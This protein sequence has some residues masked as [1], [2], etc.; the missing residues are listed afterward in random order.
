VDE[1]LAQSDHVFED[2]FFYEG[3]N[4]LAIEQHASVASVD[5]D[6]KLTTLV[7]YSGPSLHSSCACA[8]PGRTCRAHPSDRLSKRWWLR[9][10]MRP[11]NHEVV[12]S[13]AS[14]RLGRPVKICLTREEVFYMHR[15]RHPVLMKLRTG[16]TRDGK[17]TRCIY[18]HCSTAEP[19]VPTDPWTTLYSGALQTITYDLPHYKFEDV[20]LLQTSHLAVRS[21][22]TGPCNALRPGDT[23]RQ[24]CNRSCVSTRRS[25]A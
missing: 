8:R 1:A 21:A 3:N 4:H 16:V 20:A 23:T 5:G 18:K 11:H 9:R 25:C 24:D 15:G 19:T 12:V 22:A 2:L 13:R 14:L 10:Q 7:Q 17:L 6:G